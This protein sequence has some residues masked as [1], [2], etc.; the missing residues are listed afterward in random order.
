MPLN[1]N[2]M[3]DEFVLHNEINYVSISLRG[4][5]HVNL[6][7]K[8]IQ[9]PLHQLFPPFLQPWSRQSSQKL[10]LSLFE[11]RV[12]LDQVKRRKENFH[13]DQSKDSL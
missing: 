1:R 13:L 10:I 2:D 12:G 7:I 6:F 11:L 5:L 9:L 8:V 4:L 3:L